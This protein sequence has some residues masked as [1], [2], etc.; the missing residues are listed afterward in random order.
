MHHLKKLLV[1]FLNTIMLVRYQHFYRDPMY[2]LMME[3]EKLN[4]ENSLHL[5]PSEI[6]STL[7]L[8]WYEY[9][10]YFTQLLRF[11]MAINN[12]QFHIIYIYM[13]MCVCVC[14]CVRAHARVHVCMFIYPN[15]PVP[16]VVQTY[17]HHFLQLQASLM[18]PNVCRW[19][20]SSTGMR[21]NWLVLLYYGNPTT[22]KTFHIM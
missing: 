4:N 10:K 2:T 15:L 19:K 6:A 1:Q 16:T 22:L 14:V 3:T 7:P 8:N 21:L 11:H 17:Q 20:L 18:L 13:C 5:H 9:V 12:Q